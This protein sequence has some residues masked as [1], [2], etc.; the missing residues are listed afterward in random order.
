MILLDTSQTATISTGSFESN[1][2]GLGKSGTLEAITI[3]GGWT[4]SNITF[5]A[6]ISENDT[7]HPVY[8][9]NGNR[10]TVRNPQ[11]NQFISLN[12]RVTRGMRFFKLVADKVQ[13]AD[14]NIVLHVSASI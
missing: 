8:D 10:V 13:S 1:P 12:S 7:Y 3:Q 11:G 14:R 5:V 9:A 6:A 4:D 2:V